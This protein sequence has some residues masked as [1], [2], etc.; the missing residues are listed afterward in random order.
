MKIRSKNGNTGFSHSFNTHSLSE[1][2]IGYDD[3]SMD[4]DDISNFD[5]YLEKKNEWKDMGQAFKDRDI[6]PDNYN[7]HFREPKN[8]QERQQGYY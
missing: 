4:S 6:I 7:A 5:V 2:I 8:E 3:D 1:I